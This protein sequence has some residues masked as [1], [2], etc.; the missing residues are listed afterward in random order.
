MTTITVIQARMGS[1]RLPGKMLLP[2]A[3]RPL[4]HWVVA[5]TRQS[6]LSDRT[7]VATT[8]QTCD[9]ALAD[10]CLVNQVDVFR[11]S[12][13]DVLYRFYQCAHRYRADWIVRVTGDCPMLDAALIDTL[14]TATDGDASI[15]YATNCEPMTYPEGYSAEVVPMR[16]LQWMHREATLASHREHVT[17]MVRFQPQR[18]RHW[19]LR[20]VPDLSHLRLTVDYAEDLAALN[21]LAQDIQKHDSLYDA[22]LNDVLSALARRPDIR[23][24]LGSK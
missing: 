7:V 1:R 12:E 18:F 14:L 11:G 15:D 5:R 24:L 2:I 22:A 23:N 19:T 16:I 13:S 17:P 4:I 10:W 21:D 8:D 6:K 9:D 20:A 3:G